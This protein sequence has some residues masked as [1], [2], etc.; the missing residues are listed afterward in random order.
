LVGPPNTV[1][2]DL[3][4]LNPGEFVTVFID[5]LVD[6]SVP[7]G[8]LIDNSATGSAATADSNL[9]NNTATAQTL[10]NAQSDLVIAK[11]ANFLDGIPSKS[12]QYTLLV[13]NS[14]PS[15]AQDVVVVDQLPLNPK[16]IVYVVDSGNGACAYDQGTHEVTCNVGTLP[17][18]ESVSYDI[19]VDARGSVRRITN[20]ATVSTSTVDPD[21]ANNTASKEIRVKGGP[22]PKK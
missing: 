22:G 17:A 15:D 20:V 11:T 13:T 10:V 1:Q 2:C 7:D 6:A 5:V 19:I 21:L 14:G 8:T 18:G 12:I 4:D 3:N 16:K 9:A